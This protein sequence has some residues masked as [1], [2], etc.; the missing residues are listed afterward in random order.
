MLAA[1][2]CFASVF[3]AAAPRVGCALGATCGLCVAG[4][5]AGGAASF[6]GCRATAIDEGAAGAAG[7]LAVGALAGTAFAAD[8]PWRGAPGR[9]APVVRVGCAVAGFF[10]TGSAAAFGALDGDG[11]MVIAGAAARSGTT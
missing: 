3:G 10:A 4:F 7:L 9:G 5:A 2:S 6:G 8:A 11:T 1:V